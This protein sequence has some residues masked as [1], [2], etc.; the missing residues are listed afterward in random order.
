MAQEEAPSQDT[1]LNH[2]DVKTD[3]IASYFD[4]D[5]KDATT[6]QRLETIAKFLRSDT[7]EYDDIDMLRDLKHLM[8]KLGSPRM[9]T[10]MLTHAYEYAK[11][12][13]QI[14]QSQ[15]ELERYER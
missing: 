4:V 14:A 6:Q 3:S 10:S 2:V 7:K 12:A 11:I 1:E 13:S 15:K 9:G 5:G 8:F